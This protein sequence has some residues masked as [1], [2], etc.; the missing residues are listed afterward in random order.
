MNEPLDASNVANLL[1]SL[2]V[3][4]SD[5][6]VNLVSPDVSA[7]ASAAIISLDKYPGA[8]VEELRG[9]IALSHSGCV[10]LV[11]RLEA[12]GYLHRRAGTDARAVALVLTKKGRDAAASARA[13]REELL[14]AAVQTLTPEEQQTLGR[15]T[16]KLLDRGVAAPLMAMRTCRLCD[17]SACTTCPMHKFGDIEDSV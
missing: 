8:S 11:D 16:S 4:L 3:F 1:G 13:R 10:R 12:E 15:L 2:V 7:A 6:M 14:L 17:Y 5:Q 9:P